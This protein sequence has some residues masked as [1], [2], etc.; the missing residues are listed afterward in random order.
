MSEVTLLDE[1]FVSTDKKLE[2][3]FSEEAVNVPVVHQVVKATL[4]SR[5]QGNA[6]TKNRALVSGGGAK[7]FKQKGTGRARQGS[8]R[9]PLMPGGGTA[10]GPMP[11]SYEQKLNKKVVL[12]A[13]RSILLDK[14]NHGKLHVVTKLEST[15][16]TKEMYNMLNERDMSSSLVVVDKSDSL[17]IRACGNLKTA[18]ALPVGGFSV[19]ESLKYEN[20]IIEESAL[21]KLLERVR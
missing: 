11:R 8:S 10:F 14:L 2:I 20:L 21:Q 4:A 6:S 12:K 9:S 15:G 13:I 1:N 16:K 17:V 19:Y 5:R 3:S 18:R 7:P